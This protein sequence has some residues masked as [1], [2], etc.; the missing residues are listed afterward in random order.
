MLAPEN[1]QRCQQVADELVK[2]DQRAQ[3]YGIT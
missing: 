1:R 2:L 3:L